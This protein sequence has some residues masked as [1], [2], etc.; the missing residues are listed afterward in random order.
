MVASE[1]ISSHGR[2]GR[3]SKRE[4][5]P[6]PESRALTDITGRIPSGSGVAPRKDGDEADSLEP[7]VSQLTAIVSKESD[8]AAN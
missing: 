1:L 4:P 3:S 6:P 2:G 5:R 7:R 8:F